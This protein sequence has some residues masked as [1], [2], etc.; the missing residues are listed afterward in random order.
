MRCLAERV[1]PGVRPARSVSHNIFFGD[2]A[3]GV[4]DGAL[5]RGQA[6]LELPAVEGGA[7]VRDRE[8]DVAH[9]W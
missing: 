1:D 9:A 5:N 7:I 6:G 2:F 3:R 4:I 8:F